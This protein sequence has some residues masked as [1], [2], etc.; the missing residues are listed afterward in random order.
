M[1]FIGRSGNLMKIA[2]VL[3][4]VAALG[5]FIAGNSGQGS[6]FVA[7]G[8]AFLAIGAGNDNQAGDKQ[9]INEQGSDDD[10]R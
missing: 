2:G 1:S 7:L 9:A 8:V 6:I 4:L 5:M 10:A 3:F